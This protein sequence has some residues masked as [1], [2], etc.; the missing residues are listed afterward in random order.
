[1]THHLFSKI[2]HYYAPIATKAIVPLLG[3]QYH[4]RGGFGYGDLK[5]AFAKCQWVEKDESKDQE[6]GL[7]VYGNGKGGDKNRAL[8]YRALWYRALWYRALWYRA[9]VSPARAS[10]EAEVGI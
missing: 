9:D 6:L 4:D 8:W 1:V 5:E 7:D 2:P 3:K 10:N